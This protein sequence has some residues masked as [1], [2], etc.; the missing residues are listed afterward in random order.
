MK[1]ILKSTISLTLSLCL[2]FGLFA[3]IPAVSAAAGEMSTDNVVFLDTEATNATVPNTE[4]LSK[5]LSCVNTASACPDTGLQMTA[6]TQTNLSA[7]YDN[8]KNL[9]QSAKTILSDGTTTTVDTEYYKNGYIYDD[10]ATKDSV[11]SDLKGANFLSGHLYTGTKNGVERIA[12]GGYDLRLVFDLGETTLLD[13]LYLFSFVRKHMNITTYKLHV[14]DS[15]ANL[16]SNDTY[17]LY[18]DYYKGY[19]KNSNSYMFNGNYTTGYKRSEG[20]VWTFSGE[21]K[22]SGR[23]IGIEIVDAAYDTANT[24]NYFYFYEIGAYGTQ[25]RYL[26]YI[27]QNITNDIPSNQT[28][29]LDTKLTLLNAESKVLG[30]ELRM[31]A[32]NEDYV[33]NITAHSPNLIKSAKIKNYTDTAFKNVDSTPLKSAT[34]GG[35]VYGNGTSLVNSG[36][37]SYIGKTGKTGLFY[38]GSDETIGDVHGAD[39]VSADVYD[40][41]LTLDLAEST[42][43]YDFYMFNH[44]NIHTAITTYKVY[45]SDSEED[46]YTSKNEVLYWDYFNGYY[47]TEAAAKRSTTYLF[48]GIGTGYSELRRSE[49]QHWKFT[50]TKPKG[51]YVGVKVYE[52]STI[53]NNDF[54][55]IYEIGVLSAESYKLNFNH[56]EAVKVKTVIM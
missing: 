42:E 53:A 10:T 16:F 51:R 43:I 11:D 54:L 35:I 26:D 49:G 46:L 24:S 27:D 20:Q 2:V 3:C 41:M 37:N 56:G 44:V 7:K 31:T 28:K 8:S 1:K 48:N 21:E 5:K 30:T 45:I 39:R 23:Y 13:S 32:M 47:D 40:A 34:D 6:L 14:G 4:E 17:V 19:A 9:V 22:P 33:N 15:E 25:V 12:E 50:Q 36:T 52:A 55:A 38:D 29:D 18:W